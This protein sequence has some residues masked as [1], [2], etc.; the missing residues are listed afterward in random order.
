MK[1]HLSEM[2]KRFKVEQAFSNN[3]MLVIIGKTYGRKISA[4]SNIK[5]SF[6]VRMVKNIVD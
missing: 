1:N 6:D 3:S 2:S 4:T 5:N